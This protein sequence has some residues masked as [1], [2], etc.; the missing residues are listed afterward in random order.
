MKQNDEPN[1]NPSDELEIIE[2]DDRLDM[3]IDSLSTMM[4]TSLLDDQCNN[5]K[6]CND[7]PIGGFR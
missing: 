3:T 4:L 6:C 7:V 5:T 1:L 2:L